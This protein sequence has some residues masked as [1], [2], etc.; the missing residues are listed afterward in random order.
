MNKKE[1]SYR[2]KHV[3][4]LAGEVLAKHPRFWTITLIVMGAV[5][6]LAV[7]TVAQRRKDGRQIPMRPP[8]R[9]AR[10]R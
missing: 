10:G 5:A 9:R 6:I 4:E 2:D 8:V 7:S 3:A 1:R